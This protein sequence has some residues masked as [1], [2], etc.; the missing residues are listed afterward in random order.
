[1]TF[2]KH[3]AELFLVAEAVLRR[4]EALFSALIEQ[5]PVGVYVLDG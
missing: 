3:P 2:S 5:R 1:L 4:S